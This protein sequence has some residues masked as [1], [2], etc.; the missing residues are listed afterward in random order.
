VLTVSGLSGR[1]FAP[2]VEAALYFC[3]A[4]AVVAGSTLTSIGLA[5]AG[6][7]LVLRIAGLRPQAVDLASISDRVEAAGGTLWVAEGGLALTFPVEADR[8]SALSPW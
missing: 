8:A 1:R 6:G 2:R 3:C 7:D 5:V 4:E